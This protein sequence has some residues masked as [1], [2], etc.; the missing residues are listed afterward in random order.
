MWHPKQLLKEEIITAL[1]LGGFTKLQVE[2]LGW[3]SYNA[4]ALNNSRNPVTA[5]H[6]ILAKI[7]VEEKMTRMME[8]FRRRKME[9]INPTQVEPHDEADEIFQNLQRDIQDEINRAAI[10]ATGYEDYTKGG[11]SDG[12]E[13]QRQT[14]PGEPSEWNDYDRVQPVEGDEKEYPDE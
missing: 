13:P 8:V 10:L 14:Q 2:F 4:A 6:T 5:A 9:S 11:V 7:G 3:L 12:G 1:F